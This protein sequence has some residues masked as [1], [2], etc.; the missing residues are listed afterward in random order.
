MSGRPVARRAAPFAGP[1]AVL[2]AVLLPVLLLVLQLAAAGPAAAH[3]ELTGSSPR[4]GTRLEEPPAEVTL[5]FTEDVDLVDGGLRLVD[6]DGDE[7]DT[8]DA[9]ADGNTV[10]WPMPGD[11][12]DDAYVAS[13]RVVSADSHPVAGAVTFGVGVD[14][15]E[16]GATEA[17]GAAGT[18]GLSAPWPVLAAK[19]LGYAGF[20]L[21]LG[22]FVFL[23][24]C[25]PRDRKPPSRTG[26]LLLGGLVTGVVASL[27][28]L[29]L[30]GP[31][32]AG[33]PMRE[34]VDLSLLADSGHT[35]FGFWMQ[36]RVFVLLALLG[37]LW[38]D[39]AVAW[40]STR[41]IVALGALA[42]TVTFSGTGHAVASGR[43]WDRAVDTVHVLAAGTWVGGLVLVALLLPAR[44][45]GG[46]EAP[47]SVLDAAVAR[48][49]RLALGAILVLVATGTLN[50]LLHLTEV[51]D[52]WRTRYG[53]VL[54]VKLVLV[55]AALGA[56]AVSRR[57]V[58]RDRSPWRSVRVE[59]VA[60]SVVLA[61]TAVLAGTAPPSTV[62][63]PGSTGGSSSAW[64]DQQPVQGT[65]VPL[66]L[67][68]GRAALLHV[69]GLERGG[70]D[71]HLELRDA[72]GSPLA[73]NRVELKVTLPTED[74][75]PFVVPLREDRG[76]WLGT[77]SFARPGT[78]TLTLTVEDTE[79]AGI[80]T[81]GKVTITE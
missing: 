25:W 53:A 70:S 32:L 16:A 63:N 17:A 23:L 58:H 19:F 68:S 47:G 6:S 22:A 15:A 33:L 20:S 24:V 21:F 67:G 40:R 11:L 5:T 42:T 50:T 41:W 59:A 77:F 36:V 28:A 80:V 64:L 55:G 62:E 27:L 38:S 78:W 51:A 60:T 57:S 18:T 43:I 61:V 75:G 39:R 48:F 34:A 3:A 56:A 4:S 1:L 26:A 71:L 73:V 31:Y 30:H 35:R 12:P 7:V 8:P 72:D 81:T 14:P 29:L 69:A 52:L 10:H 65:T 76:S 46:P 2:T 9:V 13:W 45:R 66:D 44:E 74:L 49:S 79:L 37:V 54:L